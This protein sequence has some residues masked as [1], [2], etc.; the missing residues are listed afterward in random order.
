MNSTDE[1]LGMIC[2]IIKEKPEIGKTALMKL[3]YILQQ[4]YKVPMGY[5]YSIHTYGPYSTEVMNDVDYAEY[6]DLISVEV[7]PYSVGYT[8]YRLTP[9]DRISEAVE[10]AN[11]SLLGYEDRINEAIDFFGEKTAKELEL[12]TT[13]IYAYVNNFE[14]VKESNNIN[15]KIVEI[16]KKIKPLFTEEL[17]REE[18]EELE[19][20]KILE[21]A[22]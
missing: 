10:K 9:K 16:V 2:R 3:L 11:V 18:F 13:I 15:E 14:R 22:S 17:I 7:V 1:R 19:E 20:N 8:G 21:K 12:S 6:L 5:N 4:V